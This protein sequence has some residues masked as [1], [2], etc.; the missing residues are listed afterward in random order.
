MKH[1]KI[2]PKNWEFSSFNKFV[3]KKFYNEDWCNFD[4]R[5]NINEMDLE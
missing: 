1:Y 4:D 3:E 5:N 2:A